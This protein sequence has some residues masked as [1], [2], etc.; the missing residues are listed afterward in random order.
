MTTQTIQEQIA[1]LPEVPPEYN[2]EGRLICWE[3]FDRDR[4]RA[5][6]ALLVRALEGVVSAFEMEVSTRDCDVSSL[7]S[8]NDARAVLA[9]VKP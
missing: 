4:K 3:M 5:E 1:A 2:D 7:R 9:A 6:I 8:L